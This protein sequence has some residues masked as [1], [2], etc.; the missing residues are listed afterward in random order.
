MQRGRQRGSRGCSCERPLDPAEIVAR[1]TA[2]GTGQP[3]FLLE[4]A[5][6]CT[7]S[8]WPDQDLQ[9]WRPGPQG[10]RPGRRG[11]RFLRA[12]GPQR[13]RQDHADRHRH[14][15]GQQ[16]RR[17]G[18]RVR[19]RHRPRTGSRQVLHRHRAAGNQLQHV[20]VARDHRG[21]PGRLLRH[22]ARAG[23]RA[24]REIPEAAAAVGQAQGH[25]A[26]AVR[27]HEAPPDD[28]ARAD[29]RAAAAD[30]RRAHRGRGHRDPPLDV[31]VPARDQRA[32]H[33]HHPDH[34]LPRRGRE[35]VPQ[36]R[37]H[38]WR[39]RSSSATA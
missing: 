24:R 25:G 31:G 21:Q 20:R 22:R 12:A 10:H 11:G 38:R 6:A 26:R 19:P 16:D 23:A 2:T 28:R 17:R 9:E 5:H 8:P 34:A 7:L 30:P 14:L 18:Q 32:G 3:P 35:P 4:W 27:R 15:A 36:H 39:A 13:R 29:A 1:S 37:H 33:H